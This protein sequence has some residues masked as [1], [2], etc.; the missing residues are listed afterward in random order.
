[1][2]ARGW[3]VRA[4]YLAIMLGTVA[5]TVAAGGAGWPKH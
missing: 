1:M 4:K 5:A 2:R 3:K